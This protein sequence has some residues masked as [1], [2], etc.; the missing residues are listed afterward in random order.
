[1]VYGESIAPGGPQ[2]VSARRDGNDIVVE[3]K[4]T[5]GAL[6]TYSSDKAI[7]FEICA[8]DNCRFA[9]ATISG[10]RVV[11][12]GANAPGVTRVRYA[13]ADAP[14]VN[15]FSADDLPAA[16]FRMDVN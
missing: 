8:R 6:A 16:P 7:G 10:H 12:P 15:L 14:F 3:F 11:L 2:A 5:N 13:W 4:N 9:D 1:V